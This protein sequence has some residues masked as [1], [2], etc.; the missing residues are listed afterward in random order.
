[1]LENV[2]QERAAGRVERAIM[3]VTGTKLKSMA[4]GKM[5]YTTSQVG[6]L[7]VAA[8]ETTASPLPL[9]EG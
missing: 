6:D 9:G 8:L 2:G 1:L 7:V 5:G 4:A 3:H